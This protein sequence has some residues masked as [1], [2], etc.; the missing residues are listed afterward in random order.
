MKKS[1]LLIWMLSSLTF[2][3]LNGCSGTINS[4]MTYDTDPTLKTVR[5]VRSL[6]THKSVGFE[7]KK[8]KDN[9]VHGVNIYRGIPA[10]GAQSFKLIGTIDNRYAT[11]FVDM[12]VKPNKTYLYTFTT[13]SLGKESK[14]GAVLKVQT[15]PPLNGV[16]FIKAYTV[17]ANVVKLLWA[18][19]ANQSINRYIIER[20]VNGGPWKYVI[21][22]QG[23]LSAE[24]IDTFVHA[25]NSYKYRII[26]KSY[27]NI[28]TKT[29]Q[30]TS[31][32][33]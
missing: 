14:H 29:S 30:I 20:S 11:H 21:Q 7:W 31:V 23:Q 3:S 6:S 9:R 12:H 27:D 2:M 32:S 8:I 19:H 22:T 24:Y 5:E 28:L 16:S 13:F 26:A 17:T 4:M 15:R 33:L 1:T 25:G 18:P 10:A